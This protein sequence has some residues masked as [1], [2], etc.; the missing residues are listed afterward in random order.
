[1]RP[2]NPSLKKLDPRSVSGYFVGYANKSKG[3]RF[4]CPSYSMRIAE[5][6]RAIFLEG[7]SV[8]EVVQPSRFSFEEERVAIPVRSEER[9]CR[10]RV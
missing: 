4:Y 7:D 3:Y 6:K 2:Y 10:E 5:S 1:M 8:N 9:R